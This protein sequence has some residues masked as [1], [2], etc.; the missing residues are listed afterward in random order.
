MVEFKKILFPCDF[1][2]GSQK[3]LS[4]ALSAAEKYGSELYVFH[5]VDDLEDWR[6]V[7]GP[8][9]L[10]LDI[11]R[12]A[13]EQAVKV[14]EDFC[15]E[16][17]DQYPKLVKRLVSGDPAEQILNVIKSEDIDLVVM[18]T[19]GRRGLE[20]VFF[21]SV[22]EKITKQSPVPVMIMNPDKIG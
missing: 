18:G 19:H 1:T 16:R 14:M 4:Y 7:Y 5:V 11:V 17:L 10:R 21:G 9:S 22:A 13:L 3:V 2:E 12:Q 20:H 6:G 8:H 15:E